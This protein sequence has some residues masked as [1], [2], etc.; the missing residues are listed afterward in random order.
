[1]A[2]QIITKMV[3]PKCEGRAFEVRRGQV[4]RVIAVDGKQVGDM[5]MFNL[6]NP[7]EQ[8]STHITTNADA[9]HSF[10][11]AE[12][13]YSGGPWFNIMMTVLDDQVRLHWIHGRCN[14]LLFKLQGEE[15]QANCHDNIVGAVV[16]WGI[17]PADVRM[18]TFNVFMVPDIDA[19][20]RYTFRPPVIDKGDYLD[21]RAE[22][23]LLV[24]LS[25]CPSNRATNDFEAKAL[26]VEIREE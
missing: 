6:H 11:T 13:L 8:F 9:S 19:E 25:A 7:K 1:M 14:P 2:G 17:D 4:F 21:F 26:G 3:I 5:H 20:C 16:P 24:A 22:M 12:R 10:R 23:D 18:D 15:G